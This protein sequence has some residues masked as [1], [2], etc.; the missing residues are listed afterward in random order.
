MVHFLAAQ[1]GQGV[2][3]ALAHDPATLDQLIQSLA[4]DRGPVA[5]QALGALEQAHEPEVAVE[6]LR[7]LIQRPGSILKGSGNS[8]AL[9]V[10]A[11]PFVARTFF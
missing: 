6:L 2:A 4:Y 3:V 9:G 5:C 8:A 1:R 10:F 11:V 7:D